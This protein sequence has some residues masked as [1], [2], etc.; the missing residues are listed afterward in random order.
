MPERE[1]YGRRKTKVRVLFSGS[2]VL[3]LTTLLTFF[4]IFF[5][6]KAIVQKLGY[7]FSLLYLVLFVASFSLMIAATSKYIH[8]KKRESVKKRSPKIILIPPPEP[9]SE[10]NWTFNASSRT[11]FTVD[12]S[13]DEVVI[14]ALSRYKADLLKLM[15]L[16]YNGP[17]KGERCGI[18]KLPFNKTSIVLQCL[19]CKALFHYDHLIDWLFAH[20]TCPLCLNTIYIQ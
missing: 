3:F 19:Y 1:Q 15:E 9:T 5:F 2:V 20:H 12:L 6:R 13:R 8:F 17:T 11:D 7:F 4:F 18:C 14:N 16:L 10:R